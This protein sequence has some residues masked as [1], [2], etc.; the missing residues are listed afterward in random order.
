MRNGPA[1]SDGRATA[2]GCERI[3]AGARLDRRSRE[4]FRRIVDTYLETGEPLGSR[5]LARILRWA[6]SPASIR[7]VMADLEYLGLIYSPAYL[8]RTAADRERAPPASSTPCWRS[9]T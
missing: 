9:A 2:S 8:G 4:I 7:N 1:G 6:L 5:N 3:D